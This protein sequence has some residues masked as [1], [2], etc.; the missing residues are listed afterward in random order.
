MLIAYPQSIWSDSGRNNK[1]TRK[2]HPA[3]G[4]AQ[5][6]RCSRT[7]SSATPAA[8]HRAAYRAHSAR[9]N[10]GRTLG[11]WVAAVLNPS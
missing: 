3:P 2:Q 9:G 6:S 1:K 5:L 7:S 4:Q 10:T 8:M 11:A